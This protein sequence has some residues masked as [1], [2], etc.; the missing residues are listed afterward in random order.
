MKT[1]SA[2]ANLGIW[3]L[4]TYE[5][6][7][8]RNPTDRIPSP[9]VSRIA[10]EPWSPAITD[11]CA[12]LP[13][14]SDSPDFAFV[15]QETF[16][17]MGRRR[18]ASQTPGEISLN[19]ST[20]EIPPESRYS[21]DSLLSVLRH[22]RAPHPFRVHSH[23]SGEHSASIPVTE[24][25][26]RSETPASRTDSRDIGSRVKDSRNI[27]E[28]VASRASAVTEGVAGS[29]HP[30]NMYPVSHV[31]V[32]AKSP[33][34]RADVVSSCLSRMTKDEAGACEASRDAWQRIWQSLAERLRRL[35]LVKLREL[36]RSPKSRE[37]EVN[38][39]QADPDS[40]RQVLSEMKSKEIRNL[41]VDTRPEHMH[42]FLRMILLLQMNDYKYH[43]L[44]TTF[45]IET[46]DLEDFKYNFVNI[47][48]FRLV[49]AEDAG[50]RD[51]LR[52]MER[53][54]PSGNRI[55]NKSRVIQI[56][57]SEPTSV[58]CR[59]ESDCEFR[60]VGVTLFLSCSIQI[61]TIAESE[62]PIQKMSRDQN[63]SVPRRC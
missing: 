36:V 26:N 30:G 63:F 16:R 39:R 45:D 12:T 22:S 19:L 15:S 13:D 53:Y 62:N 7:S 24:Y 4:G 31:R 33:E 11:H 10:N 2:R 28:K 40:Y 34:R 6:A 37:I 17:T 21:R 48:A 41:I 25:E 58:N 55:L 18:A 50:V 42:H 23:T 51:I 43:Y 57:V 47:T 35:G 3:R 5:A 59:V 8:T 14:P 9:R 56:S 32:P 49:D 61:F 60:D 54:Q 1:P 20:R 29:G 27:A 38:L 44:F 46:F 52:D